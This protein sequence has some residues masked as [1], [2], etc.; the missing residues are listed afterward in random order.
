MG[1]L[2]GKPKL[3]EPPPPPPTPE[4]EPEVEDWAKRRIRGKRGFRQTIITGAL[5]PAPTGKKTFFG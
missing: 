2:F 5:T 3:P 4:I 1:G